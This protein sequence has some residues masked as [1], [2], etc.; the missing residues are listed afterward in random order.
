[1]WWRDVV[2]NK[3]GYFNGIGSWFNSFLVREVGNED[4]T[5]FWDDPW[6]VVKGS[7]PAAC[8]IEW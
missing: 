4:I 3:T 1:M 5:S 2:G 6:G 7:V 8:R